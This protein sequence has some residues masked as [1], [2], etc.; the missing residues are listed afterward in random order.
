MH[1]K[2]EGNK[3]TRFEEMCE[4]AAE[5]TDPE[6]GSRKNPEAVVRVVFADGY[7]RKVS[8]ELTE[9]LTYQDGEVK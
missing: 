4:V 6:R 1:S 3:L 5:M 8:L 2:L 9:K 7:A